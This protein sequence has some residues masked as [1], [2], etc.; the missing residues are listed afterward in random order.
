[1]GSVSYTVNPVYVFL[2]DFEL[3]K[4]VTGRFRFQALGKRSSRQIFISLL[5]LILKRLIV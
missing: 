4:H 1:M 3:K 5:T 2:A